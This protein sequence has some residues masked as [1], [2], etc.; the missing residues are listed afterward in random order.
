MSSYG[1]AQSLSFAFKYY[2]KELRKFFYTIVTKKESKTYSTIKIVCNSCGKRLYRKRKTGLCSK[3]YNIQIIQKVK[4]NKRNEEII[5]CIDCGTQITTSSKTGL[6]RSCTANRKSKKPTKEVFMQD[7]MNLNYEDIAHK[8]K[9]ST[10]TISK[11]I[12]QYN[13]QGFRC[14]YRKK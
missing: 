10:V 7:L 6:C 9:I 14:L 11:W 1:F 5:T 8:Y 13:L 12:R 2:P 3:C 4:E